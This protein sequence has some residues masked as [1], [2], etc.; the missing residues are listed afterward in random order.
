MSHTTLIGDFAF[1]HNGDY[2][3]DVEIV[4]RWD[5]GRLTVPVDALLE[6]VA[7]IVRAEL[8]QSLE[9]SEPRE[10]LGLKR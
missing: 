7:N 3:G 5:T 4:R 2:S 6:F 9:D 8:M 1:I 10:I